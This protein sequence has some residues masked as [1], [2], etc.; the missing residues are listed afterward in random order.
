MNYPLISKHSVFD[1]VILADGDFPRHEIPLG[2]LRQTQK[3]ICCDGAGKY[4][5]TSLS[6]MPDAIVGDGDSL[7]PEFKQRY[8][9]IF[10]QVDEQDD[11]DLTKATRF[12]LSQIPLPKNKTDV[13]QRAFAY[14]AATG[15]REDHTLAN[16]ALMVRYAEEF[17]ISPTLITDYGWFVPARGRNTFATSP[18]QQVSLFNFS[19]QR[20]QG[21]G[22][23]WQPYAYKQF[24]QGSLNEAIGKKTLLD[25]DGT[26][27]VYRAFE[28]K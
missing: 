1:T 9:P 5:S 13:P 28:I 4:I 18:R 27:L 25:G 8:A 11:N 2:I 10:H 26:Y 20:L 21:L 15:K 7:S 14:L 3:L 12:A 19:C 23:R 16:I 22:F 24:W 6:R 17:Q